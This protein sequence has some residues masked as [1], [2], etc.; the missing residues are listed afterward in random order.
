MAVLADLGLTEV[1]RWQQALFWPVLRAMQIGVRVD[2][3]RRR[4]MAGELRAAIRERDAL[5]EEMLGHPLN[6]GSTPQMRALFYHDLGQRVVKSHATGA[7]TLND[8]ALQAIATR[9]PLL[10]P[11]VNAIADKRTLGVLKSTFIDM[12]LGEDGRMRT[13]FNFLP[14]TYRFSSSEDAFGSGGNLENIPSDKSR[15][16]GRAE[17]RG[18]TLPNVREMFVPDPGYTF[19]EIDLKRAD[20]WVDAWESGDAGLKEILRS[21]ADVHWSNAR[22]LYGPQATP[23]QREMAKTG[24]H[25]THKGGGPRT[26]AVQMG[27]SVKEA[28]DF[29]RR[30]FAA[31]PAIRQWLDATAAELEHNDMTVSN[32]FGYRCHFFD[33]PGSVLGEAVAWKAQSTVARVI[34]EA[35]LNIYRAE[36]A[37][38]VLL[39]VHDSIAGQYPS[40]D[41]DAP[42]RLTALSAIPVPYADPL[43]IPVSIKTSNESWGACAE[44]SIL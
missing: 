15:A 44:S 39:Q 40:T 1:D 38:Q 33:R 29:Q 36:P 32:R 31:H 30:W 25:L 20:L 12:P 19:F 4:A 14:Y 9:E 27:I 8:E 43:T 11:L 3:E 35:W 5:I 13:S 28:A 37:V 41:T 23:R 6:T 22:D 26:L 34:N 18:L 42:R 10:R 21:G 2:Q 7:P 17:R 24:I 16:V